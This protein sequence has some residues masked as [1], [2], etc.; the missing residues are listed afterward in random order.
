MRLSLSVLLVSLALPV[1]ASAQA[2]APVAQSDIDAFADILKK[3]DHA[4][5]TGSAL[6][7]AEAATASGTLNQKHCRILNWDRLCRL[8]ENVGALGVSCSHSGTAAAFLWDPSDENLAARVAE[9]T[10]ELQQ[11]NTTHIHEFRPNY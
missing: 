9:A 1:L 5:A 11:L 2:K 7:V 8:A 10:A 4:I 3:F 6:G